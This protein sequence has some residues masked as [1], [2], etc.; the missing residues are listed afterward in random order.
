[1]EHISAI[2]VKAR[3]VGILSHISPSRM[4][5]MLLWHLGKSTVRDSQ[6]SV[7]QH[8]YVT[9][10]DDRFSNVLQRGFCLNARMLQGVITDLVTCYSGGFLCLTRMLQKR[11]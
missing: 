3:G 10:D 7:S 6:V 4:L 1:M 9:R 8:L 2:S 5:C 11:G